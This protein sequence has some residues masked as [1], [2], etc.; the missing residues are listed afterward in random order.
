VSVA[1]PRKVLV[2][3]YTLPRDPLAEAVRVG[4]R[5]Y[6]SPLPLPWTVVVP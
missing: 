3:S 1:L 2:R 6:S 5:V 4:A